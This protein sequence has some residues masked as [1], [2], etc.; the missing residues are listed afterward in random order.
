MASGSASEAEEEV[1]GLL[2][3]AEED[4]DEAAGLLVADLEAGGT[5][6]CD[7]DDELGLLTAFEDCSICFCAPGDAVV[8]P[9]GALLCSGWR[10]L[11][12]AI[13]TAS[14]DTTTY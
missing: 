10:N 12:A 3:E 6:D 2:S 1:V 5:A 7:A 9:C 4:E 13:P 8:L 11:P 14:Y